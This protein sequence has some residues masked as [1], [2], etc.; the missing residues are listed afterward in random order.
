[1]NES[2]QNLCPTHSSV[3][4]HWKKA[5]FAC[6]VAGLLS[7]TALAQTA[8]LSARAAYVRQ[9]LKSNAESYTPPATSEQSSDSPRSIADIKQRLRS[10]IGSQPAQT[11]FTHTSAPEAAPAS[12][13]TAKAQPQAAPAPVSVEAF[14]RSV[15]QSFGTPAPVAV[16]APIVAPTP[17]PPAAPAPQ[18]AQREPTHPEAV[19]AQAPSIA[20]M[21]AA[22]VVAVAE[23]PKAT[24]NFIP[25]SLQIAEDANTSLGKQTQESNTPQSSPAVELSREVPANPSVVATASEPPPSSNEF[26]RVSAKDKAENKLVTPSLADAADAAAPLAALEPAAG[27]DP[28]APTPLLATEQLPPVP[29]PTPQKFGEVITAPA[30]STVKTDVDTDSFGNQ[31][32]PELA[33]LSP[34]TRSILE[35]LPSD[36]TGLKQ[37]KDPWKDLNIQRQ[38]PSIKLPDQKAGNDKNAS[39]A[40]ITKRSPGI[41]LNYELERA[42]NALG[43][44]KTEEAV[45]IYQ[46]ILSIDEENAQ[47]LFGL[48]TT[49]HKLGM[50]TKAAPLYGHLLMIDPHNTEALN[51]FLALVGEESPDV[52]IHQ[53]QRMRS[54]NPEFTPIPAQIALLYKKQKNYPAAIDNMLQAVN[55]APENLAYKFNLAVMYDQGGYKADAVRVYRELMDAYDKGLT[56][57]ANAKAIQERLTFLASN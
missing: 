6:F 57:P 30:S 11:A 24:E 40:K 31:L 1:M 49:W 18:L 17:I 52:A 56:L 51:N 7:T 50:V 14:S 10:Q 38:D 37:K 44:G 27:G 15:Q 19:P 28:K 23:P 36:L 45:A 13:S 26:I 46:N 33:D 39:G 5:V 16:R 55:L 47:A 2:M 22:P 41:D 29:L 42:Y 20:P 3:H 8:N 25:R 48:A 35:S 32:N 54:R 21:P 9:A 43:D 53:M 12:L 34:V 4:K